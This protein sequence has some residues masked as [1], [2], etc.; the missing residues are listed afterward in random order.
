MKRLTGDRDYLCIVG[1]ASDITTNLNKI[2]SLYDVSILAA[3][4]KE[5][6]TVMIIVERRIANHEA[7]SPKRKRL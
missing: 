4:V 2:S 1:K 6:G 5:N 3:T 7:T